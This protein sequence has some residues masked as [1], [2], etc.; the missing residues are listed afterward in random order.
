MSGQHFLQKKFNIK[1]K[2]QHKSHLKVA[3]I[4]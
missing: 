3:D 1:T 2:E 4:T